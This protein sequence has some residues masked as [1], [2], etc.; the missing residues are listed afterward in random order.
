[1]EYNIKNIVGPSIEICRRD[2]CKTWDNI[3]NFIAEDVL[4]LSK[5]G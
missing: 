5:K 2:T 4:I 1:M 3:F